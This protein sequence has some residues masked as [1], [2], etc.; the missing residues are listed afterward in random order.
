MY[1]EKREY[2]KCKHVK[3]QVTTD[4][5]ILEILKIYSTEQKR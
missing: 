3:T 4:L 5:N 1:Y 2:K